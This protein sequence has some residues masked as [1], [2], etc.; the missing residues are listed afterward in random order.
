MCSCFL[1]TVA[2]YGIHHANNNDDHGNKLLT[3]IKSN[4]SN[5]NY[6]DM[7]C[8]NIHTHN[9]IQLQ[10]SSTNKQI[11]AIR[12][13]YK[14]SGKKQST[15]KYSN[16]LSLLTTLTSVY[17]QKMNGMCNIFNKPV[18]WKFTLK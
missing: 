4:N 6:S 2:H 10:I 13:Q 12:Q 15:Y 9:H 7:L 11:K 17:C 14:F 5:N 18:L 16:N 1:N 3:K 8:D